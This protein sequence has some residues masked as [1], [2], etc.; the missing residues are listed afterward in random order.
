[1]VAGE[2]AVLERKFPLIVMAVDRFVFT[3]IENHPY[4]SFTS[5]DFQL[6]NYMWSFDGR[7]VIFDTYSPRLKFVTI[8]LA[9]VLT[10]LKESRIPIT[11][12]SISI[13]SELND[14]KTGA[15]YGLGSSAAVVTSIISAMLEKF[16]NEKP[17]KQLIFK[18]AAIAH[19]RAQGSGSGA[20]IAA[21][22][23]GGVL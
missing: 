19:V 2:F 21:S 18:L 10:Y 11:P 8:A 20:D 1:M 16:L 12:V 23:Y 6:H 5:E 14:Q 17:E 7:K 22:T 4:N 3:T 15:K 9:T 13:R